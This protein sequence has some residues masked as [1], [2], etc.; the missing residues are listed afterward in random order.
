MNQEK[1]KFPSSDGIH[2]TAVYLYADEH[3]TPVAVMQL[4][5]GMSEYIERYEWFASYFTARGWIVC[6]N[7]H[8]GHGNSVDPSEYGRFHREDLLGDLKKVNDILHQRYPELPVILYGHSMGSFFARWYAEMYPDTIKALVLSG[9]GGPMPAAI[10]GAALAGILAKTHP[11]GYVSMNLVKMSFGAYNNRIPNARTNTDWLSRDN[12]VVD[13]YNA[14]PKAGFYFTAQGYHEMLKTLVHVNDPKWAKAM[15]K[16][17]P[18][19]LIAGAEDPVGD[20][21]EGVRKV[22]RMLID[23]G[24]KNVTTSIRAGA[25]HELHNEIDKEDQMLVVAKW[26]HQQGFGYVDALTEPAAAAEGSEEG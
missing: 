7:D 22:A 4:S 17:L 25:R 24:A 16:D 3:V 23:A 20:Y 14:D 5:H 26:L 6:G 12:A 10:A 15:P 9:T 1:F 8:I 2:E 11:E 21:G 13:A 19:L 18:I